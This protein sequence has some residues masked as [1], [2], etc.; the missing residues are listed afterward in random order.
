MVVTFVLALVQLTSAFSAGAA[1]AID[2]IP[3]VNDEFGQSAACVPTQRISYWVVAV[4]ENV[5]VDEVRQL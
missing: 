1:K 3:G 5:I 2:L 4:L